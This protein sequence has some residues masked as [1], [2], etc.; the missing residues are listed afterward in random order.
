M[1]IF[2]ILLSTH[3]LDK[4]YNKNDTVQNI[5]LEVSKVMRELLNS[6][7]RFYTEHNMVSLQ[8]LSLVEKRI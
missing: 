3:T 1:T 6:D 5:C 7:S 8:S 4:W 2:P